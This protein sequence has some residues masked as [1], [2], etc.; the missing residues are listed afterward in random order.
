[1]KLSHTMCIEV[2]KCGFESGLQHIKCPYN[3]LPFELYLQD[4]LLCSLFVFSYLF[5]FEPELL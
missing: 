2:E 5:S 4:N 3:L 1:V